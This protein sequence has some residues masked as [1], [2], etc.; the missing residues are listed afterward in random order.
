MGC[1]QEELERDMRFYCGGIERKGDPRKYHKF[2]TNRERLIGEELL[3]HGII[4]SGLSTAWHGLMI[5]WKNGKKSILNSHRYLTRRN[6]R[7][8][9]RLKSES[10]SIHVICAT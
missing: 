10:Q 6:P 5:L 7:I 3:R 8:Q 2:L 9:L 1:F 4:K